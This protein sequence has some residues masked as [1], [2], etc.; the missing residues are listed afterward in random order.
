MSD[1]NTKL[2]FTKLTQDD[3]AIHEDLYINLLLVSGFPM[4]TLR[5]TQLYYDYAIK[6]LQKVNDLFRE[7][8][9]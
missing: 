6:E 4:P 5:C 9:K 8:F 2:Q 3:I 7:T 1:K